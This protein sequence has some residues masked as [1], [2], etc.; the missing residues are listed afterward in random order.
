MSDTTTP[1]REVLVLGWVIPRPTGRWHQSIIVTSRHVLITPELSFANNETL[2]EAAAQG[3]EAFYTFLRTTGW[4]TP[5]LRCAV[6]EVRGVSWNDMTGWMRIAGAGDTM[7][8]AMIPDRAAGTAMKPQLKNAIAG[9][10][11][12]RP[13]S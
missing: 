7:I 8:G 3:T 10:I 6:T 11:A 4:K 12:A 1:D 9:R 13:N 5:P 2:V